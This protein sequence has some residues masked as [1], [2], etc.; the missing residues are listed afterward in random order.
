MS[1]S[2]VQWARREVVVVS[3]ESVV[4]LRVIVIAVGVRVQQRRPAG[5]RDERRDEQ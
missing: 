2:I 4:V 1:R 5:R 3:R